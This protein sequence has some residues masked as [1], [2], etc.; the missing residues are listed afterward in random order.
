MPTENKSVMEVFKIKGE[1][2]RHI[3]EILKVSKTLKCLLVIY[4]F[5]KYYFY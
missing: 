5:N 4:C 2:G 3:N 1:P